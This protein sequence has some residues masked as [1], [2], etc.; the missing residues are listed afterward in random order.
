[1]GKMLTIDKQPIS[2]NRH[3]SAIF[4]VFMFMANSSTIP[5]V[6]HTLVSSF[7]KRPVQVDFFYPSAKAILADGI[8]S[9]LLVHDGQNMEELGLETILQSLEQ[10]GTTNPLLCVA[11]HCGTDRI[12]EYGV[13][14]IP[15]FKGRGAKAHLHTA[16]IFEELLPFIR[17]ETGIQSFRDKSYAGFSLGGLSALDIVWRHP[18]EFL[19]VGVFSGSL[20]WRSKD[21]HAGYNEDTDRIIHQ[22]IRNGAFY[23]WLQ[24]FFETGTMDE[25]ADRNNNG[26]IDSIDDT[27]ALIEELEK[28]GYRK[29]TDIKYL[30]LSDGKHDVA[31]WAKAMPVF[32]KWGWGK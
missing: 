18:Q 16:F 11:I 28:K 29:D 3:L 31:T 30:E 13:A 19:R 2:A 10:E 5:I 1:M 25:T 6:T 27:L 26:I 7:L 20:W 24:F 32:L 8:T 14:G 23:P 17:K 22:Q 4:G 21:L 15:D 12:N 9:L